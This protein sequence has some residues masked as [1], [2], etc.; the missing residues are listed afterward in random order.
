MLHVGVTGGRAGHPADR[1]EGECR[2]RGAGVP[3]LERTSM[4]VG[5]GGGLSVVEKARP[6]PG[7]QIQGQTG[8][9]TAGAS[10]GPQGLSQETELGYLQC[11]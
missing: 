5:N 2:G 7:A 6:P 4:W 3:E 9:C 8:F 10:K 11:S 1:R